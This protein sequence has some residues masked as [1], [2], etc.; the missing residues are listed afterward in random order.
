MKKLVLSMIILGL[1][2]IAAAK[3]GGSNPAKLAFKN[4][5]AGFVA[6][7]LEDS[8]RRFSTANVE[9]RDLV[10]DATVVSETPNDSVVT[11]SISDGTAV[12]YTCLRFDDWSKGGTVLKKEVVCQAQ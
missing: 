7:S 2:Q 12:T 3:G 8:L 11:I 10:Q 6:E 4:S 9:M 5:Q 1:S